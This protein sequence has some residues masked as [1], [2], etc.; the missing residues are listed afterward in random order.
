MIRLKSLKNIACLTF[1]FLTT[2][3]ANVAKADCASDLY[4]CGKK[5]GTLGYELL[6]NQ[7]EMLAYIIEGTPC[8]VAIAAHDPATTVF[9]GAIVGLGVLGK[10]DNHKQGCKNDIYSVA[11]KPI[12][13]V[14]DGIVPGNGYQ[15]QIIGAGTSAV[16]SL[17]YSI[18]IPSAIPN[19]GLQIDCGCHL[20][21]VGAKAADSAREIA[22]AAAAAYKA[23]GKTTKSC[24][25][26]KE[27][28][29]AGK[30]VVGAA[31]DAVEFV[32]DTACKLG[33]GDGPAV[34]PQH[35]YQTHFEYMLSSQ[36]E[37]DLADITMAKSGHESQFNAEMGFC[38]RHYDNRCQDGGRICTAI[39]QQTYNPA[40]YKIL[41]EKLNGELFNKYQPNP[42]ANSAPA[43]LKVCPG[44][45]GISLSGDGSDTNAL[46]HDI[47]KRCNEEVNGII[48]G[49]NGQTS[50]AQLARNNL[51]QTIDGP[52]GWQA[53]ITTGRWITDSQKVYAEASKLAQLVIKPL[54]DAVKDKYIQEY[55]SIADQGEVAMIPYD[56]L[57]KTYRGWTVFKLASAID[58]CPAGLVNFKGHEKQ[59][60]S[61]MAEAFGFN[62]SAAVTHGEFQSVEQITGSA[63]K[64]SAVYDI[65][66]GAFLNHVQQN[67]PVVNI[68]NQTQEVK[69]EIA[70]NRAK[71]A[72]KNAGE[73]AASQAANNAI[74][75]VLAQAGERQA[76]IRTAQESKIIDLQTQL[77]V[78]YDK[79]FSQCH[80]K[81]C[82]DGMYQKWVVLAD[83][84][85]ADRTALQQATAPN[86]AFDVNKLQTLIAQ[87][88]KEIAEIEPQFKAIVNSPAN[89]VALGNAGQNVDS[90]T[91][92][93]DQ[94]KGGKGNSLKSIPVGSDST[95][96]LKNQVKDAG[97]GSDL[98]SPAGGDLANAKPTIRGIRA[99]P[100]MVAITPQGAGKNQVPQSRSP[101]NQAPALVDLDETQQT[102]KD[103]LESQDIKDKTPAG[104]GRGFDI[105][106]KSATGNAADG[107]IAMPKA[108]PIPTSSNTKD[109]AQS[110]TQGG[111]LSPAVSAAANQEPSANSPVIK[112]LPKP[113]DAATGLNVKD[114]LPS[115]SKTGGL[116]N[117]VA[118]GAAVAAAGARDTQTGTRNS[119]PAGNTAISNTPAAAP[120]KTITD[121]AP[122]KPSPAV[123]APFDSAIYQRV[124]RQKLEAKWLPLCKNDACKAD[125]SGLVIKRIN[126]VLRMQDTGTDLRIKANLDAAEAKMDALYNPQMQAKVDASTKIIRNEPVAPIEPVK[127]ISNK[128]IKKLSL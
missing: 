68:K 20:L 102:M 127:P 30:W 126:E 31:G 58:K 45:A 63:L 34:T 33:D 95:P 124:T 39:A 11:A 107:A 106:A 89:R 80:T 100:G 59:C 66:R 93:K 94:V 92:L 69:N 88:Q 78:P 29:A 1:V 118:A 48:S 74:P 41:L 90:A 23:C 62:L 114:A 81:E 83:K 60:V 54:T 9:S 72:W 105:A 84:I 98:K 123:A 22:T 122:V 10:I 113:A 108:A 13:E 71:S 17:F 47:S 53:K 96:S 46:L 117:S 116:G 70:Y 121:I 2:I 104:L 44:P 55:Q 24:P 52:N 125:V 119:A 3:T 4:S 16:E 14:V 97:I 27:A 43:N 77:K 18:Q 25:G 8:A 109:A 111:K 19:V 28:L 87:H 26:L 21:G 79:Y 110:A 67:K 7:A 75:Q 37:Q 85:N 32:G 128:P 115:P 120:V 103:K 82:R 99:A 49:S 42:N 50:L 101:Q 40:Y 91:S 15:K 73:P 5:A 35:M 65:T 38:T 76:E 57:D 51:P 61:E 6:E 64:G 86:K 36:L 12:A 56:Y 112:E